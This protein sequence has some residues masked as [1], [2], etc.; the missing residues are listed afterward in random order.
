LGD[1]KA[2]KEWLKKAFGTG[3]PTKLKF[4]ALDEPDLEPLWKDIGEV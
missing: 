1:L 3:T 4:I 2:A